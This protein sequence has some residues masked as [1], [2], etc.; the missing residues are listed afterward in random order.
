MQ[1]IFHALSFISLSHV[2]L[3]FWSACCVAYFGLLRVSEF[4]TSLPFNASSHLNVADVTKLPDSFEARFRLHIKISKTDP[5]GRG[6]F[7][8]LART[9]RRVCSVA[10]LQYYLAVRGTTPGPLF[11]WGDDSPLTAPQVNHY[12]R[13]LLS[14]M[15]IL[16]NYSSR[17][18]R[19][20]AA[21]AAAAAGLPDHLIQALGR[22]TSDAYRR[23]IRISTNM[24]ARAVAGL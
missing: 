20:G 18:F 19:I 13:L 22:W 12:M 17:S 7:I 9:R 23:Y 14:R 5:F 24:L 10:A 3:M 8:Y 15:R 4:T 1:A 2:S 16:G 21:T 11:V 6:C